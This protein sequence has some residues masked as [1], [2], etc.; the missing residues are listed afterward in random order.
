[1]LARKPNGQVIEVT[2]KAY[3]VLYKQRG[4][5]LVDSEDE[6]IDLSTLKKAELQELAD[7]KGIEYKASA[8]KD[9]LINLLK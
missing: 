6:S 9:E 2:E 3:S 5:V 8:T 4:W 1:M 7:K